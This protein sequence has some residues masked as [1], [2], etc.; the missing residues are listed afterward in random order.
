[1]YACVSVRVSMAESTIHR[2]HAI[3]SSRSM[4]T[5]LLIHSSGLAAF[6]NPPPR[7]KNKKQRLIQGH[8]NG[9]KMGGPSW[10]LLASPSRDQKEGAS[11]AEDGGDSDD[12]PY[13]VLSSGD[14]ADADGEQ[15]RE[16][17]RHRV[18]GGA[19]D[20]AR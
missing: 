5:A 13:A 11:G 6:H 15:G 10:G 19:R 20:R 16:G 12:D 8:G 1:M 3:H 18:S 9:K 7:I 17:G 4:I 14:D 2:R